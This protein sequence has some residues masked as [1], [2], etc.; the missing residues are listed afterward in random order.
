MINMDSEKSLQL[1]GGGGGGGTDGRTKFV[2]DIAQSL[3]KKDS[4]LAVYL[5]LSKAFLI[6]LILYIYYIS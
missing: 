2:S 5:D 3:D 6:L 1:M 4:T